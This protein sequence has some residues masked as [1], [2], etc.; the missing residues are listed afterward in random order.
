M[1][2][3]CLFQRLALF[4]I[5]GSFF[6]TGAVPAPKGAKSLDPPAYLKSATYYSD[7]WVVN[8]WNSESRNMDQEM[9]K[10]VLDGFNSIILVIPWREFQV[11]TSRRSYN[12]YALNKLNRVMQSAA[13]HGLWVSLRIG[14]TWDYYDP[15]QS[16]L[17]RYEALLHDEGTR[18]AWLDYARTIYQIASSH[19]NFYGGFITWEDFWDYTYRATS[20]SDRAAACAEAA[21]CGYTEY[22][23]GKYSLKQLEDIYGE[24]LTSYKNIYLPDRYEPAAKLFYE[25]YD[26]FLLKLLE[27]T[28]KVFPELSM[29]VRLDRDLVYNEEGSGEYYGHEATYSC[30]AAPY[31]SAMFSI[32]M[33]QKNQ[34]DEVSAIEAIYASTIY[35]AYV[36]THAGGKKLYLEQFLFTDNTPGFEQ[37]TRVRL[38]QLDEYLRG[39]EPAMRSYT[40][41]YGIWA[42]RDYGNN[43]LYNSQFALGSSGWNISKGVDVISRS[44]SPAARIPDGGQIEQAFNGG[45]HNGK[46]STITVRFH[47]DSDQKAELEVGLG[48]VK[49]IIEV[50]G[51]GE[52]ELVYPGH[53]ASSIVFKSRG[54][55]YVDN[56]NVYD[57]KQ[58]GLLYD[59]NGGELE[60]IDAVRRMN[61]NL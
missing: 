27:D 42:Y 60:C 58:N 44:G 34:G 26:Q 55:V 22:L 37:N 9:E 51:S 31:A 40:M 49:E 2:T 43:Q 36:H 16:V 6:L 13:D 19:W 8:F 41:G 10:I 53:R 1:I 4:L 7:D 59:I 11:D 46:E 29:E 28:Q 20:I 33:G 23:K 57:H 48:S 30:G 18:N 56:V 35:M 25:F 38:D 5:L 3:R 47:A 54:E 50:D 15:N 17:P 52:Y 61:K 39:M 24:K 32:A 12:N 21:Q 45:L 14:Y